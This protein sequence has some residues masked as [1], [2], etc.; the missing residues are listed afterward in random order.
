MSHMQQNLHRLNHS[1]FIF[2]FIIA[3][4]HIVDDHN[5][6]PYALLSIEDMEDGLLALEGI[7]I[8]NCGV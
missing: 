4:C 1:I 6:L 5:N 7:C 2:I 3:Y 8:L